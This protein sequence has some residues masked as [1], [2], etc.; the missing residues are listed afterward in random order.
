MKILF[1]ILLSFIGFNNCFSQEA[2]K[3]KQ[4]VSRIFF[5]VGYGLSGSFF[6][7]SY[8]EFAPFQQYQL[9]QKKRF[10][11]SA[12]NAAVGI[13]FKKNWEARVGINYQHFTKWIS[14][15]DTLNGVVFDLNHDIHHRDYMWYGIVDKKINHKNHFFVVGL[16]IYYL[17]TKSQWVE[18]F[19]RYVRD[20]EFYLK[21]S[22]NGEAGVFT[23]IAYEY[24]FQPKVHLGIKSQF[25]F[26]ATL[27]TAESITLFPYV[28]IKF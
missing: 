22:Y 21:G 23:E 7:R 18:V 14:A 25:Y 12:Q 2:P 11:G 27:G 6:V 19:P 1:I 20:V 24:K 17:E 5:S 10:I 26:T 8:E 16:G 3:K 13:N 28:V 15:K 9:F 4:P